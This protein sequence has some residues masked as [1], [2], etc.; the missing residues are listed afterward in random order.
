MLAHTNIWEILLGLSDPVI[1]LVLYSW[2]KM[3]IRFLSNEK[4]SLKFES[5]I[6]ES[7]ILRLWYVICDVPIS[8][9]TRESRIIQ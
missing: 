3:M 2:L 8:R 7:T 5:W 1:M 6:I 9:M 4:P